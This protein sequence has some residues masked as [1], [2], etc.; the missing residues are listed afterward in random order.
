MNTVINTTNSPSRIRAEHSVMVKSLAKSGAVIANDLNNDHEKG[1]ALL[2]SARDLIM[3]GEALDRIKKWT[4]YNK[5]VDG[6]C[7]PS[8]N[9]NFCGIEAE[10]AHLLHMAVG[11]AGEAAELL[12]AVIQH[13]DGEALNLENCLEELG[14]LEFYLE[15]FRQGLQFNQTQTLQHNINKLVGGDNARYKGGV[16][17]DAA[18]IERADKA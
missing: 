16:Y 12:E 2:G 3:A 13:I 11:V 17:S 14:D 4:V 7:L 5:H 9:G 8:E 15:G 1:E 18:A 6:L 10:Q